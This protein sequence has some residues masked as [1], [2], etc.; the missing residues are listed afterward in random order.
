MAVAPVPLYRPKMPFVFT[1]CNA[2]EVAESCA[3]FEAGVE[4]TFAALA[5]ASAAI[6]FMELAATVAGFRVD[7]AIDRATIFDDV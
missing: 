2:N 7:V 4:M 3:G 1:R 5:L 6:C